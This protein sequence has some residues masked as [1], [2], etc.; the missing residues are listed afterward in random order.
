VGQMAK[1]LRERKRGKFPSQK[2]PNPRGHEELKAVTILK[3]GKVIK[4]PQD[5][6]WEKGKEVNTEVSSTST[7]IFETPRG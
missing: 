5:Q 4:I 6:H 7:T 2:I 1:E 3:S